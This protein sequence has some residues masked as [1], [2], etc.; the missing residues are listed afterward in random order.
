MPTCSTLHDQPPA[1]PRRGFLEAE[2]SRA[3]HKLASLRREYNSLVPI[4]ALP[5]DVLSHIFLDYASKYHGNKN[6]ISSIRRV[7]HVCSFWRVVALRTPCLYTLNF[8]CPEAVPTLLEHTLSLLRLRWKSKNQELQPG[9]LA[10]FSAALATRERIAEI[11]IDAPRLFMESI[12]SSATGSFPNLKT[13]TLYQKFEDVPSRVDVLSRLEAPT[14]NMLYL[15][16]FDLDWSIPILRASTLTRLTIHGTSTIVVPPLRDVVDTLLQLAALRYL[17]WKSSLPEVSLSDLVSGVDLSCVQ[18][19]ALE[20]VYIRGTT[21]ACLTLLRV[22]RVPEIRDFNVDES[23]ERLAS[24][25]PASADSAQADIQRAMWEAVWK[26]RHTHD[27][28]SVIHM[29]FHSRWVR[30][31]SGRLDMPFG[32]SAR[33]QD[34][35]SLTALASFLNTYRPTKMVINGTLLGSPTCNWNIFYASM[36][37]VEHLHVTYA[38]IM[39]HLL[40]TSFLSDTSAGLTFPSLR[41]VFLVGNSLQGAPSDW[42]E[43]LREQLVIRRSSTPEDAVVIERLILQMDTDDLP[44]D[45]V[46]ALKAGVKEV[47]II[48]PGSSYDADNVN[49]GMYSICPDG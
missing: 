9:V 6:F 28:V 4:M 33:V 42:P 47:I 37:S 20:T 1:Q 16:Y 30:L 49:P 38:Q 23:L 36:C 32:V 44:N 41:S 2:I 31:Q 3:A 14:L 11:N 13:L 40:K 24:D 48:P 35:L 10:A 17:Y 34:N 27:D 15:A 18:L 19:P 43:R 12:L 5:E 8:A 46:L 39:K 25:I 22:L 29:E 21:A 7:T 45:G 26:H